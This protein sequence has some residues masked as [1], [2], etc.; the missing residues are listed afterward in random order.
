[1]QSGRDHLPSCVVE[2][3]QY[4]GE[5][6][7]DQHLLMNDTGKGGK[8]GQESHADMELSRLEMVE[9]KRENMSTEGWKE[10][11]EEK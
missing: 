9:K 4:L 2:P 1:M 7:V 5:D 3:H 6:S 11:G 8:M 10:N